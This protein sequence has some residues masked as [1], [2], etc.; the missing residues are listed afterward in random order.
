[1][2]HRW[3]TSCNHDY[4]KYFSAQ[5]LDGFEKV[6]PATGVNGTMDGSKRDGT[7]I[8][9]GFLAYLFSKDFFVILGN[10]QI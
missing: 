3:A 8:A 9:N 4:R 7:T 6:F 1:M 2:L 10:K 5:D